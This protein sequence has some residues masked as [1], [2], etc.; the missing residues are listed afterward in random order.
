MGEV[1][2]KSKT[3][4]VAEI[5]TLVQVVMA[6]AMDKTAPIEATTK[7]VVKALMIMV[8]MMMMM[9]MMTMLIVITILAR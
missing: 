2:S 5:M 9:M 1:S 3:M 4:M 8:M 7:I 6:I